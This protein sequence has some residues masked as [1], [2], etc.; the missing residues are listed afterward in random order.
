MVSS[1]K[2][3]NVTRLLPWRR[4]L[5]L[6]QFNKLINDLEEGGSKVY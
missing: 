4:M 3:G 2:E 5:E 1:W 6:V